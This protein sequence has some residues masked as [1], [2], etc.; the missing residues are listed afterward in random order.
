MPKWLGM[1]S[2]YIAAVEK[3]IHLKEMEMSTERNFQQ[4]TYTKFNLAKMSLGKTAQNERTTLGSSSWSATA[5]VGFDQVAWHRSNFQPVGLWLKINVN[6]SL[7]DFARIICKCRHEL[8]GKTKRSVPLG[9]Q[10]VQS[11]MSYRK[12]HP[13]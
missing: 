10:L 4:E 1:M 6:S 9:S 7:G 2:L 11:L 12:F 8:D 5:L 3:A 13:Q